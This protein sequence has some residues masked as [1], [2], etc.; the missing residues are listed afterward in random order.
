MPL[1]EN[2]SFC[3]ENLISSAAKRQKE[4]NFIIKGQH[5]FFFLDKK[6]KSAVDNG[7]EVAFHRAGAP[8]ST[9]TSTEYTKRSVGGGE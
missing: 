5:K 4:I 3:R 9:S 6:E 1:E 8:T 2:N 7:G